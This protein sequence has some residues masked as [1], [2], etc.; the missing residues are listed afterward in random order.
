VEIQ[1][2]ERML[3]MNMT[4]AK[5]WYDSYDILREELN[6][7][8]EKFYDR[9]M[10][11]KQE[12][13]MILNAFSRDVIARAVFESNWQ[14]GIEVDR[15]RTK[16]LADIVFEDFDQF[17]HPHLDFAQILNH[18]REQVVELRRKDV[19]ENELAAYN[20]S[21]A[22][23]ALQWIMT[24]LFQRE[25]ASLAFALKGFEKHAAKLANSVPVI[26]RGFE[27]IKELTENP[28]R[29]IVPFAGNFTTTGDLFRK[30]LDSDFDTLLHPLQATHLHFLHRILLMGILPAA[31]CGKFR[32]S[33]V[34]VGNPD[35][36]F[37]PPETVPA[38]MTEFLHDFPHIIPHKNRDHI[39]AAATFS[40]RFV[41]IHPYSDGNGRVSRLLMNLILLPSDLPIYLK[42]DKKGRHRYSQALR[43]ADRGNLKP[44]ASLIALALKEVYSKV[45]SSLE[46]GSAPTHPRGT[47]A[48]GLIPKG[49]QSPPVAAGRNPTGPQNARL[50]AHRHGAG[51]N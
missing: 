26:E 23:R 32:K 40:F 22:H 31:K 47:A 30:Y 42:A 1:A 50:R 4:R 8:R 34:H 37:P 51:P 28:N 19:P 45:I 9:C 15:G 6:L 33:S 2:R 16:E 24:E 12:P 44:L 20:L 43:R 48:L 35:I 11:L 7:L 3:P 38:M 18:H 17:D 39:L 14:E 25:V 10:Q 21:A 49:A 13:R 27:I 5:P 46:R 29:P 36:F 41:R